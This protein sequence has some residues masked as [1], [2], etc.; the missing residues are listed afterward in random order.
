MVKL[1]ETQSVFS[2]ISEF[3]N[4]EQQLNNNLKFNDR[5]SLMS[6]SLKSIKHK[7]NRG[8]MALVKQLFCTKAS[9]STFY[10]S[11]IMFIVTFSMFYLSIF[12]I[13]YSKADHS[14]MFIYFGVASAV[15]MFL[16]KF[17]LK[18]VKDFEVYIIGL[19][20][21]FIIDLIEIR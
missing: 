7:K 19:A 12:G 18:F 15:G 1:V 3:M 10:R 6:Q 21:I 16:S 2:M 13:A 20:G 4:E 9:S 14:L 17:L 11:V 5:N 8:V